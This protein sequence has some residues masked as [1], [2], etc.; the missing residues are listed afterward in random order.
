MAS[1]IQPALGGSDQTTSIGVADK[2]ILSGS[3]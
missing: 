2:A 1:D 3:V